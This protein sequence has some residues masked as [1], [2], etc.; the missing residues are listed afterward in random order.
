MDRVVR[1]L[2]E[3]TGMHLELDR[4]E[5]DFRQVFV[6]SLEI[7]GRKL[8]L[9]AAPARSS[10]GACARATSCWPTAIGCWS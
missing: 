10:G 7:A 5:Y 2:G 9:G 1:D 8:R 3:P 6:S 4:S